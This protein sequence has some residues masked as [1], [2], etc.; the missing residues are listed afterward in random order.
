VAACALLSQVCHFH[1]NPCQEI[2]HVS[3]V[4]LSLLLVVVPCQQLPSQVQL[5]RS[6]DASRK[7][8]PATTLATTVN[9]YSLWLEQQPRPRELAEA[10]QQLVW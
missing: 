8:S 6:D 7:E 2:D 4:K 9:F 10:Q 1:T 3:V 5:T